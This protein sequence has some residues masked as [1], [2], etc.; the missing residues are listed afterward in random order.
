MEYFSLQVVNY[1]NQI[2]FIT[3]WLLCKIYQ[4]A[5]KRIKKKKK[6]ILYIR[7]CNHIVE[8]HLTTTSQMELLLR[9]RYEVNFPLAISICFNI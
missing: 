7:I 6:K 2:N 5:S 1:I 8:F 9:F 3:D 4:P